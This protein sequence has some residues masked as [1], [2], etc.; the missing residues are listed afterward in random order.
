MTRMGTRLH[1]LL[2]RRFDLPCALQV[3]RYLDA[4]AG[5]KGGSLPVDDLAACQG[6]FAAAS[7]TSLN[8]ADRIARCE[9]A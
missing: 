8:A 4:Y 3:H 7:Q 9:L 2:S 6:L 1:A 5:T